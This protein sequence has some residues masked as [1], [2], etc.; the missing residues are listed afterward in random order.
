MRDSTKGDREVVVVWDDF[1]S[2]RSNLTTNLRTAMLLHTLQQTSS[3][4]LQLHT[5]P[6]PP[7]PNTYTHVH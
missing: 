3:V 6:P 7:T 4:T 5:T 1:P 2:P